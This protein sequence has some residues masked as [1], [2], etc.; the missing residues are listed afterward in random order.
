MYSSSSSSHPIPNSKIS[1]CQCRQ[2]KKERKGGGFCSGLRSALLCLHYQA[3]EIIEKERKDEMSRE[4]TRTA[5]AAEAA[6]FTHSPVRQSRIER[7]RE[8]EM[9][10]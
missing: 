10:S 9:K 1:W 7:E 4:E 2:G 5:A 8:G 3:S 6:A